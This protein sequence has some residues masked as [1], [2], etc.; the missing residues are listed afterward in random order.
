VCGSAKIVQLLKVMK[1]VGELWQT[2]HDSGQVDLTQGGEWEQPFTADLKQ[3]VESEIFA[4]LR[5]LAGSSASSSKSGKILTLA[6]SRVQWLRAWDWSKRNTLVVT[7]SK[8]GAE[9]LQNILGYDLM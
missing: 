5:R 2:V 3:S 4:S 9:N 1:S 8:Q 6:N 7:Y